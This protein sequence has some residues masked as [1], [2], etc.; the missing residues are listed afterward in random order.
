V[1]ERFEAG[2]DQVV[3]NLISVDSSTPPL[4]ELRRLAPLTSPRG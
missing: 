4:A 1:R 2:A 3:L